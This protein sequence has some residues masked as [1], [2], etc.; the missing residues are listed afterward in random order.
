[1]PRPGDRHPGFVVDV[2]RCWALAHA[3][4]PAADKPFGVLCVAVADEPDD[5][6][7]EEAE[8][9]KL[10]VKVDKE[11]MPVPLVFDAANGRLHYFQQI[12]FFAYSTYALF[13][14][15]IHECLRPERRGGE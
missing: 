10:K 9:G 6:A 2:G 13:R 12:P 15:T 14:R 3:M 1:M 4:Q 11:G 8:W 7:V 5:L